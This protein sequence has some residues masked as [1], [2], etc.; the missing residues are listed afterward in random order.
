MNCYFSSVFT[1]EQ[2][3]LPEFDNSIED[4]LNNILC[5]ANKVEKHLKELNAHKSQGP[6]MI[7]PH[8]LKEC[9]QELSTSLCTLF[10]K[11]FTCG[12]IPTEWKMANIAP[13][14]KKGHKHKK[15]NYRQ[16]SLTSIVCKV[17]EKIVRS[18][19]VKNLTGSFKI[20]KDPRGSS[21]ILKN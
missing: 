9:A 11:P 21:K 14:H 10:N 16:V 15:E 8:I 4:K 17:A 18:S 7:S 6:D 19:P 20:F 2:S 3:D 5:N 1:L 12:Y 13:I